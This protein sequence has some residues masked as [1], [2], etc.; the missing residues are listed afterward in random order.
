MGKKSQQHVYERGYLYGILNPHSSEMM[1][2]EIIKENFRNI[3]S[4]VHRYT[5]N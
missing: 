5:F 3:L 2:I 1:T 4:A